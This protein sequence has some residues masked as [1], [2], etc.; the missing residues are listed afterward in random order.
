[1]SDAVRDGQEWLN[2]TYDGKPGYIHVAE[3][4]LPGTAM[5]QALVSAMQ[6]EL[7]VSP[8]TGTFGPLTS[9]MC[10]AYPLVKDDYGNR[11][12]IIQYGLISKGYNP[13]L[14]DSSLGEL[15]INAIEK[16]QSD[17]GLTAEQQSKDV[18]GMQA[19]AILGVDEYQ[20]IPG[21]DINIRSLQQMLN[22]TY[23]DYTGICACDGVYSR[24][25]NTALV[26]ALQ[27][28]EGMPT[29]MA[30]GNFG[31]STKKFIPTVGSTVAG[32]GYGDTPYTASKRRPFLMLAQTALYCNGVDRYIGGSP[33]RYGTT[34]T[35]GTFDEGT[36]EALH[37]FQSDYGLSTSDTFGLNEWMA[38]L[39]STGNP[40]RSATA[41]DCATQLTATK[42]KALY[43]AGY[44]TV[45]R[46]LTGT[47]GAG[48]SK[49]PKDISQTE[50]KAIFDAGLTF[51]AIFQDDADWWQDHDSL[52]G[53]FSYE[54]GYAD[55]RKAVNAAVSLGIKTG[56]YIY[57]AVDYDYMADE[58]EQRVIPHFRAINEYMASIGSPYK[59]G[60]YGARN[61]CGTVW[62]SGLAS[63]SFV[64]DMS[65]GYS[66]NL[67]YPIPLNWAFDQIQEI[68]MAASDGSFGIDRNVSSGTYKGISSLTESASLTKA[69]ITFKRLV[70]DTSYGTIPNVSWSDAWFS[71]S[72]TTYSHPLA[73]T[74]ATLST[75]A[76]ADASTVA[77][78]L[79][80]FGFSLSSI[81]VSSM[82]GE[83]PVGYAFATKNL[84][85]GSPLVVVLVRGTAN[86][87]EW[88]SNMNVSGGT[89]VIATHLG[90]DR[91]EQGVRLA[92][93]TWLANKGISLTSGTKFLVTGHSRG[94]AV[95][96]LLARRLTTENDVS[97]TNLF[98]YTFAT[99]NV[100]LSTSVSGNIFNIINP[101]DFVPRIPLPLWGFGRHGNQLTLPSLSNRATAEWIALHLAMMEVY[102]ELTGTTHIAFPGGTA[103]TDHFVEVLEDSAP[104]LDAFY[105]TRQGIEQLTVYDYFI[106]LAHF[107]GN[108]TAD[109][110]ALLIAQSINFPLL[111]GYFI[112]NSSAFNSAIF[113][114]HTPEAYLAWMKS[115][116]DPSKLFE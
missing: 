66:G 70:G 99:P 16:I 53:Y 88:L 90:F 106:T 21:G 71:T 85:N 43:S 55:A 51:F 34:S 69:D 67:G 86:E 40:E 97:A 26:Y 92:L 18:K 46:Y 50:A 96:N 104:S 29:S 115:Q 113:P 45:G 42:A 5:S 110:L 105:N 94:A 31:P 81:E 103:E 19:K 1:M 79:S 28:E 95:A 41:C 27:A 62:G 61:T 116:T 49:R 33:N 58:I 108:G 17:A 101:E 84:S 65:T 100:T 37:R 39:V 10:D 77:S 102:E 44:R 73:T 13:G 98:G 89:S 87:Q 9:S 52:Q 80:K 38:L 112:V 54:R 20:L 111:S 35:D 83:D 75:L 4:G 23:L 2:S 59:I 91:A 72:T 8:V 74:A 93:L 32:T 11:V 14:A 114:A 82:S 36:K 78:G 68:T 6:I 15:C 76:Y 30:N 47:V 24:S 64:S 22:R 56:E 48:S 109:N 63:S 25:T 3:T 60:V 107:V 57:F 12:R 7:G